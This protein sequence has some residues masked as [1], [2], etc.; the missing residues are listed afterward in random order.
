MRNN[1][2]AAIAATAFFVVLFAMFGT[3]YTVDQSERGVLT[4]NGAY[5]ATS[6]PGLHFKLP[7]VQEVTKISIQ[8]QSTVWE[9]TQ[10][11][12]CL[13]AYSLDQQPADLRV[14]VLWH[15]VPD[16]AEQVYVQ[17]GGDLAAV[18]DRL[19][20]RK[21]PQAVKTVF[22]QFTAQ[23]AIQ[24]RAKLNGAVDQAVKSSVDE[25]APISIDAVNI[26]NI[27]FSDAYEQAIEQRMQAEVAVRKR[28]QDLEQE[29]IAAQIQVTQA[30][31]RADSQIAEAKANA[32]ATRIQGEATAAAIKA[33][34]DALK[35]NP[36]LVALTQAE[37][38]DG[39]LPVTMLPSGAVPMLDLRG[40]ATTTAA[41]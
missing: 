23:S 31:G 24:D 29:K 41:Q 20:G 11:S 16:K 9:C 34:G 37:R 7:F 15:T 33:R 2:V 26:E 22:G 12:A 30:Q 38:W 14:S 1:L 5:T 4:T 19:I 32:E 17:Y 8:Q 25:D 6:A 28:Q 21:V 36:G 3:W 10:G 27:D 18:R 40:S 35:D 13:Q 39:K